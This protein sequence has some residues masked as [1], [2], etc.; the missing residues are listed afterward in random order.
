MIIM[1]SAI[2]TGIL[3][4]SIPTRICCG[5]CLDQH[6]LKVTS[7]ELYIILTVYIDPAKGKLNCGNEASSSLLRNIYPTIDA[8]KGFTHTFTQ[9]KYK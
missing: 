8:L 4:N 2:N 7:Q 5:N 1:V 3:Y 9:L 6:D